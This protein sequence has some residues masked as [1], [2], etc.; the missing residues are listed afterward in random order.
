LLAEFFTPLRMLQSGDDDDDLSDDDEA[1]TAIGNGSHVVPVGHEPRLR[2]RWRRQNLFDASKG[3]IGLAWS[4]FKTRGTP[5]ERTWP[6]RSSCQP[7][8]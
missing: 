3:E 7:S 5:T 1:T 8:Q 4:I 2:A 6:V